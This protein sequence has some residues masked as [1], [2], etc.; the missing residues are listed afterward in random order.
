MEIIKCVP[1]DSEKIFHLYEDART[2][3]Q[4]RKM[5]VWPFFDKEFLLK[6]IKEQMQWKLIENDSIACNWTITLEDKDIWEEKE[7]GDAIYIHR[8]V[9]NPDFRGRNLIK[10]LVDWAKNHASELGKKYV[11]LDTLGNNTKLIEHYTQAG[12]EFLGIEK[13]SN[14]QNLPAHYQKEPNC[15]LFQ[16]GL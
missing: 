7:K 13:L 16:I 10:K 14:T 2:L 12:F 3:Q 5:V 15:C 6:E 11:R 1:Q 4:S 8:I 9:T